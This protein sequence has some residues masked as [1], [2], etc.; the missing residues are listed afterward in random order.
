MASSGIIAADGGITSVS[1]DGEHDGQGIIVPSYFMID[2]FT[3]SG[4]LAVILN[5]ITM[6]RSHACHR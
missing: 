1:F 4:F 3:F 5:G 2:Y 6:V